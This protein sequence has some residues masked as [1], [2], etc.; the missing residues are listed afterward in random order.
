MKNHIMVDL[1][2]LSTRTNATILTLGAVRFDPLG[3]DPIEEKDKLYIKID[4][5]SCA[6]LDLHIDDNT[7]EWWSKQSPE[8][9]EE[10]FGEEGRLSATDAFTQLYKFCWGASCFWSNGAGFDIV[11]C[12]TYYDR[13][14]RAAPWKYWA[15][16][17]VRTM[18]DLGIDPKMPQV[19]AHNAVEDAVAQ[20]I[21]VQNVSQVLMEHGIT[22]FKKYK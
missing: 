3:N 20:A 16:R 21:G 10:A 5:D 6:D 1:E 7:I 9:Q 19:T 17:D 12:D 18:F 15:I 22:P 11:V 4:L 2:T 8:A 14:Q 13:I